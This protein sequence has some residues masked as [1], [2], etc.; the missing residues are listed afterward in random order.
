MLALPSN[1]PSEAGFPAPG[2]CRCE[3]SGIYPG[4]SER[5]GEA[6]DRL[7]K[8]RQASGWEAAFRVNIVNSLSQTDYVRRASG[9]GEH[10]RTIP[11]NG[12]H[13]CVAD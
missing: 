12:V 6:S 4:W 9:Q 10:N 3:F 5:T 11:V 13:V 2:R 1:K 8:T 7:E